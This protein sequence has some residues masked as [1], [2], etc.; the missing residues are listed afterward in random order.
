ML[1][2]SAAKRSAS[3]KGKRS[4]K[5]S[6]LG[7]DIH[8]GKAIPFSVKK[9]KYQLA[10]YIFFSSPKTGHPKKKQERTFV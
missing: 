1:R 2:T 10:S 5:L 6:S 9:K 8:V 3:K 7:F 4:N